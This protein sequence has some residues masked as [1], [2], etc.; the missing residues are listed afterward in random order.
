MGEH[1]PWILQMISLKRLIA[2]V[3]VCVAAASAG[4]TSMKTIHP[5]TDP[6]MRT[7][8]SVNAGDTVVVEMRDGRR[9]RFV[10]QQV[11]GDTILSNDGVRYARAD[12]AQLQR[13]SVSTWKT[14]LLVAAAIF[15]ALYVYLAANLTN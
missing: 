6:A 8:G 15:A 4:C 9:A 7:F 1:E 10:V 11:D 5:V 3:V 2:C 14:A 12:I 13:R